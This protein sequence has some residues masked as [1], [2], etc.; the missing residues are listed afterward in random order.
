MKGDRPSSIIWFERLFFAAL[1]VTAIDMFFHRDI[2][3]GDLGEGTE[4]GFEILGAVLIIGIFV[5]GVQL[6]LWYFIAHRASRIARSIYALFWVIA[7]I[8]I[9]A[10]F[11]DY[12]ASELVFAAI[13]QG[14]TLA[15]LIFLFRPDAAKWFL[16]KGQRTGEEQE[17]LTD[18]FE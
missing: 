11:N 14:L 18:I 8:G 13:T 3:F 5:F 4:L 9:I 10:L 12:T 7:I 2:L 15:S 17:E 16:S 1:A 6:L